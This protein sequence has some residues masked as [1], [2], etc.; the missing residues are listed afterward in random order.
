MADIFSIVAP[1]RVARYQVLH[2]LSA[3]HS[4]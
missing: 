2:V 3:I 1:R 4:G